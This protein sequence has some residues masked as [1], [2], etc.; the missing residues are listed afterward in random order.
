MT[1]D[2]PSVEELAPGVLAVRYEWRDQLGAESQ[3]ELLEL[4]RAGS[5]GG[6][7]ALVFVLADRIRDIPPTVRVFWRTITA[8]P[9]Y[10]IAAMAVVT[11]SWGVEVSTAGF[12]V[13]SALSGAPLKVQA[14]REERDAVAWASGVVRPSAAPVSAA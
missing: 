7:I 12:G 9:R 14:F 8:D 3:A 11:A 4:S 2:R 10:R 6:P 13:T 5:S 1:V